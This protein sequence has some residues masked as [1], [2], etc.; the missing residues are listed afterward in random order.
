MTFP[1]L[2]IRGSL[3][4]EEK[5]HSFPHRWSLSGIYTC[6]KT[7]LY[8]LFFPVNKG[9]YPREESLTLIAAN[10]NKGESKIK[11]INEL[12]TSS[13]LLKFCCQSGISPVL[14]SMSGAPSTLLVFTEPERMSKCI[15]LNFYFDI[16]FTQAVDDL[17]QDKLAQIFP[18]PILPGEYYSDRWCAPIDRS[19]PSLG[20][21]F[22]MPFFPV[23]SE[24]YKS[25][26]PVTAVKQI[27]SVFP[28]NADRIFLAADHQGVKADPARKQLALRGIQHEPS[29]KKSYW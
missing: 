17:F 2:V 13:N 23:W 21:I 29:S 3:L 8:S 4:E 7:C 28:V 27:F 25:N 16:F 24:C 15:G 18:L 5:L 26:I 6:G 10:N 12:A 1:H 14:R 20:I 19:L 11:P 9:C 22:W